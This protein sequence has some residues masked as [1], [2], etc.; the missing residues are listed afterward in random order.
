MNSLASATNFYSPD[1]DLF[2]SERYTET[3]LWR[4]IQS[5]LR[6]ELTSN[7]GNFPA[8]VFRRRL[9]GRLLRRCLFALDIPGEEGAARLMDALSSSGNEGLARLL[10][11]EEGGR[12]V[13]CGRLHAKLGTGLPCCAFCRQHPCSQV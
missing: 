1:E 4:Q 12:C 6:T 2:M 3:V 13:P 9:T 7:S 11:V 10:M 8:G 5:T